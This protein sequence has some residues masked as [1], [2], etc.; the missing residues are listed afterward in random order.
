MDTRILEIE[1]FALHA[2]P[3]ELSRELGGWL[4]RRHPARLRRVNSVWPNALKGRFF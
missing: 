2:W 4:I 1:T 3:P